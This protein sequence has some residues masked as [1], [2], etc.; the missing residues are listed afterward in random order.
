MFGIAYAFGISPQALMTANPTVDPRAMS[1]GTILII[2]VTPSP[3]NETTTPTI[4]PTPTPSIALIVRPPDCYPVKDGSLWCFMLVKNDHE[5]GLENVTGTVS[6]AVPGQ[7]NPIKASATTLLDLLQGGQSAPLVAYFAAPAPTGY[8]ASGI[9]TSGLPQPS[10]DQ[11]YLTTAILDQQVSIANDGT[12][13]SISGTISLPPDSTTANQ[14]W[15]AATAYSADGSVVGVRKWEAS[16]PL[17][18]GRT[19]P[20]HFDI[21]SLGAAIDHVLLQV[22]AR[23]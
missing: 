22:E 7:D 9:V 2:P 6:L 10:G 17:E 8:T 14:V 21:Y 20:I 13:A 23:P 12:T 4:T 16:D 3:E 11:R 5:S 19:I 15:I 18:P 1:I